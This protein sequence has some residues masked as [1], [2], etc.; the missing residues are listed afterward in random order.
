MLVGELV[1]TSGPDR[2]A[3]YQIEDGASYPLGRGTDAKFQLSDPR[4]SRLHCRLEADGGAVRLID[5]GSKAGSFVNGKPVSTVVLKPGDVIRVGETELRYQVIAAG[6]ETITGVQQ[7]GQANVVSNLPPSNKLSDL[8]GQRISHYEIKRVIAEGSSGTI[9]FAHDPEHLRGVALKVLWPEFSKDEEQMQRFVRAMKTMLPLQ[10]PNLVRLFGAGKTGPHCW[11]AMEHVEGSNLKKVIEDIG[12]AGMLDWTYA[13]KVCYSIGSA[14]E[15][16]Y[17]HQI[18]HRN[19]TPTNIL[20]RS[21]DKAVKLGDMMLA[22]ALEGTLAEQVTRPGQIVGEMA[23]MSPERTRSTAE[24]DTRSDIYSLGATVY[25][26][27]TGHPPF[28]AKSLPD[29]IVKI[30]SAEVVRPKKFQLSI[31]DMFEGLVLRMLSKKPEDR[32][33]TPNQL[34]VDLERVAKFQGMTM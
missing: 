15:A 18:L 31:P 20:V 16:A 4:A 13:F 33:A 19:I 11:I 5:A 8:V 3:K 1:V 12:T 2:G 24:V 17:K 30:R 21:N 25:A 27:L 7:P 29:L 10:H 34:I 9:F 28:E 32:F 6:A 26:L 22:K 23:Y 14:L